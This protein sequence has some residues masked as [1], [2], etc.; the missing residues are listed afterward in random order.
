MTQEAVSVDDSGDGRASE[1]RG[2]LPTGRLRR[3]SHEKAL[4][5]ALRKRAAGVPSLTI[6]EAAALCSV[7]PEHLYRM[8]RAGAFPA[9]RM[10]SGSEPGRYVVPASAVDRVLSDAVTADGCLDVHEWASECRVQPGK[11]GAA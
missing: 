2:A 11:S 1:M 8:V 10:R 3:A 6:A 9:L 4:E 7:S 5:T